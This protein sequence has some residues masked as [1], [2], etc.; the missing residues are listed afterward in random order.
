MQPTACHRSH[1]ISLFLYLALAA[2]MLLH[3]DPAMASFE[4]GT[5]GLQGF[6]DWL[7][8]I[9]PLAALCIAAVLGLFYSM[10]VIRKDTLIQWGTGVIFIG[11]IAGGVIKLFF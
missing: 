8:I 3:P 10:D 5:N 7:W 1:S 6:K 4:K 9:V 2:L 11:A